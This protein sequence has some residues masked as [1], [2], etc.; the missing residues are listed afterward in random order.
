[1]GMGSPLPYRALL[2]LEGVARDY[3]WGSPTAIPALLD[4]PA[5]GAPAAELWFGAHAGGSATVVGANRTLAEAVAADP[6]G[7]LGPEVVARFGPTLP[8]MVKVIAPAKAL[9]IQAHPTREQA[10]AG[11]DAEE[12]RGIPRTDPH[13]NYPDRNHKPELVRALGPFDAFCGFRPVP[14]TLRL[15]E[16]LAVPQFAPFHAVLSD[17]DG[18]RRAVTF[19]LTLDEPAVRFLVDGVV[20][21]CRRLTAEGGE[22]ADTADAIV[23][24]AKDFPADAGLGLIV[25]LN[26]LRLEPGEAMYVAPGT[27]HCY[28]RGLGVEVMASSDNV[29]RGG[30]TPK[31]VDVPELL[32][33]AD[34]VATADPRRRP[35]V[36]EDE[37]LY[38]VPVPDF[39][40]SVHEVADVVRV[41]P[42]GPQIVLCTR[43]EVY[44]TVGGEHR[45]LRRGAAAFVAAGRAVRVSGRGTLYRVTAV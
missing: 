3:A 29:L 5:T 43:G 2:P 8:F 13:R 22:W 4:Q 44:V 17:T 36:V 28:L 7:W 34:F 21:A 26:Y 23:T 24:V 41:A 38:D 16:A 45:S 31:H 12:A 35:R 40:L 32:R 6:V 37:S 27:V 9:S 30:L 42:T 39:Q 25:L 15:L 11:F 1:M 18:P 14:D 20:D 33:V 19:L 10:T